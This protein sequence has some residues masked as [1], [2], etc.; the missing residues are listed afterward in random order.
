MT[1]KPRGVVLPAWKVR[2]ALSLKLGETMQVRVPMKDCYQLGPHGEWIPWEGAGTWRANGLL[3][4]IPVKSRSKVLYSPHNPG[5]VVF[6]KETWR[7]Y[8]R[9]RAE[10]FEG[11]FEYRTDLANRVF[12][13]FDD[14]NGVFNLALIAWNGGTANKWRSAQTLLEDYARLFFRVRDVRPERVQDAIPADI[15]REGCPYSYSGTAPENAPDWDA[16]MQKHWDAQHGKRHPWAANGWVWRYV[17]ERCER[18][19]PAGVTR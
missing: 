11:G 18:A 8:G 17:W 5:D 19:E 6:V 14:P 12:T 3:A 13:E 16:W 1:T 15:Q 7:F 2:H 10:E 9:V 4:D